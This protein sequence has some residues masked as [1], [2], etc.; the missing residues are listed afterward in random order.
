MAAEIMYSLTEQDYADAARSQYLHRLKSPKRWAWSLGVLVVIF[1]LFAYS[2][3]Y[4]FESFLYNLIPYVLIAL[5]VPPLIAALCYLS[6]GRYARRMFKQQSL[7][8][9]N[10]ASWNEEGLQIESQLGFLKAKWSD[11]YGWRNAGRT[12]MIHM[13]EALYYLIPG[14][15]LSAE[16][17]VDLESTLARHGVAKR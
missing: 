3:S 11:F 2:D 12:Y 10:R 13:N 7:K 6:A 4:D 14:R 8:P 17:A 9:E 5:L 1:G 15:A 16:Q